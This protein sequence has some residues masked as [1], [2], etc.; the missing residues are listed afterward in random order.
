ML[1]PRTNA[2]QAHPRT[3]KRHDARQV[4]PCYCRV[5]TM[6]QLRTAHDHHQQPAPASHVGREPRLEPKIQAPMPGFLRPPDHRFRL[7]HCARWNR[8]MAGSPHGRTRLV[9][10][11]A[12]QA[13][14]PS[15]VNE[16]PH[17]SDHPAVGAPRVRRLPAPTAPAARPA[18]QHRSRHA[19]LA[20]SIRISAAAGSRADT[21]GRRS[22]A[23]AKPHTPNRNTSAGLPNQA[24]AIVLELCR[25]R[26]RRRSRGAR[27]TS[28]TVSTSSGAIR[29]TAARQPSPSFAG[30]TRATVTRARCTQHQGDGAEGRNTCAEGQPPH[31]CACAAPTVA[32]HE[33][34]R[35]AQPG[36]ARRPQ[37]FPSSSARRSARAREQ[38][39]A[40]GRA[41]NPAQHRPPGTGVPLASGA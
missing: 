39:P 33:P 40:A 41:R 36:L 14:R 4:C 11:G 16:T 26:R 1:A 38:A 10:H 12:Q 15:A 8:G 13:A 24:R 9:V 29:A 30:L 17:R 2:Q 18:P 20:S 7:V 32:S 31:Q 28:R 34:T 27:T 23:T 22:R 25:Q 21:R 35:A 19:E 5:R 6:K 37:P 3:T